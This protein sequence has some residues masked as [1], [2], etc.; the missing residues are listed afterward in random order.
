MGKIYLRILCLYLENF[1]SFYIW[2]YR[3]MLVSVFYCIAAL[4]LFHI[5][6]Y[7][8]KTFVKFFSVHWQYSILLYIFLFTLLT[9][10]HMDINEIKL[11]MITSIICY[12]S[13]FVTSPS[14]FMIASSAANRITTS[15]NRSTEL[16][17]NH[18][19]QLNDV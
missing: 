11:C 12:I 2:V 17:A 6:E 16:T 5:V 9:I 8:T 18:M 13:E 4:K 3:S 7:F 10:F 14:Y 15:K 19:L 1:T